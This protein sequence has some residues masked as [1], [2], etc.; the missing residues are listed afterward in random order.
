MDMLGLEKNTMKEKFCNSSQNVRLLRENVNLLVQ[1]FSENIMSPSFIAFSETWHSDDT[2]TVKMLGYQVFL[3]SNH[4]RKANGVALIVDQTTQVQMND[5]K[6]NF[7]FGIFV[8]DLFY[9]V[10]RGYR[11]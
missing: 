8:V 3:A 9:E 10:L 2:T 1:S 7:C 5:L 6:N 4:K 11:W